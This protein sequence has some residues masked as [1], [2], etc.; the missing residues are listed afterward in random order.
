MHSSA[1]LIVSYVRHNMDKTALPSYD[2]NILSA[3]IIIV[4]SAFL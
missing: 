3:E 4:S 2:K 1:P